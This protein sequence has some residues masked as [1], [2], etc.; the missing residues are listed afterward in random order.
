MALLRF[1][2]LIVLLYLIF[3]LVYRLIVGY[4][5]RRTFFAGTENQNYHRKK[6]GEVTVDF[7]TGK[8]G[9]KIP[10]EEGEYIKFEELEQREKGNKTST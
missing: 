4:N 2:L 6:D 5:R 8:K 9:K 1:L 7:N 10:K 3:N